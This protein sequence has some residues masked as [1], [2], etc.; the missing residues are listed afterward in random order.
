MLR[1][2]HLDRIQVA[3]DDHRLV[4]NAGLLLPAALALRPGLSQLV[5]QLLDLGDAPGQHRRQDNDAG[6]LRPGWRRLHRRRR[7]AASRWDGRCSRLP[8]QG[9]IHTGRFPAQLSLGPRP[10]TGPGE[11]RAAGT[12]MAGRT[13]RRTLD[14]RPRFHRLRDL[15]TGQGRG[16]TPWLHRQA[17]LSPPAPE[18][19]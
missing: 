9:A 19:C 3:F 13:R 18:T 12:G 8:G 14:Y 17:G 11:P 4:D 6:R 1:R 10:P 15:R 2:N 16:P 7:C 5:Q